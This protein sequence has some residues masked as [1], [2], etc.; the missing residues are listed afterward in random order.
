MSND[1]GIW[2]NCPH[3]NGTGNELGVNF[4]PYFPPICTVC[5]GAKI[6][7]QI[8]GLPPNS[9]TRRQGTDWEPIPP[10]KGT[11]TEVWP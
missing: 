8:T 2:Q 10:I 9:H 3:C 6:I 4:G 7:S 5:N 1:N 11:K